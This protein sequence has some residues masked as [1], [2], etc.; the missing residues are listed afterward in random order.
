[1]IHDTRNSSYSANH[2][3][4]LSVQSS[5]V[6]F[7]L[8]AVAGS[9]PE[10]GSAVT[11]TRA[12]LDHHQVAVVEMDSAVMEADSVEIR[13]THLEVDSEADNAKEVFD[14]LALGCFYS[15]VYVTTFGSL[16]D[17]F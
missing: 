16:A 17:K 11:T 12:V 13:R 15:H 8:T 3:L 9:S 5:V 6:Y 7:L 10:M 2:H 14:N 4:H 1:M